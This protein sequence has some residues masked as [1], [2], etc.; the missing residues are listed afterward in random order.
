MQNLGY[1]IIGLVVLPVRATI[2][3]INYIIEIGQD[4]VLNYLMYKRI[5]KIDSKLEAAL[6]ARKW[7]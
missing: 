3:V 6:K 7:D 4:V 5:N 2:K 1:F